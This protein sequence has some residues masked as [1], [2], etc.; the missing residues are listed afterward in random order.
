[1]KLF[2]ADR[3][4]DGT[5]AP[6]LEHAAVLVD[7]E[8]VLDAGRA[9]DIGVPQGAEVIDAPPDGTLMPGLIDVHVH[10]AYSGEKDSTAFRAESVTLNYPAIALRAV[11]F[12]RESLRHGFTSV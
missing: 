4:I 5:G 6:P 12:A 1:M 10:L 8:R 2:R 7:G 3:L 9:A 11:R